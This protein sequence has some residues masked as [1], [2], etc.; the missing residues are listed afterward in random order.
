MGY[1]SL[2]NYDDVLRDAAFHITGH[3]SLPVPK[4]FAS[5]HALNPQLNGLVVLAKVDA[6]LLNSIQVDQSQ[7]LTLRFGDSTFEAICIAPEKMNGH[8]PTAANCM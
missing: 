2:D 3:D 5:G 1:P 8:L 7:V 6:Q 4:S